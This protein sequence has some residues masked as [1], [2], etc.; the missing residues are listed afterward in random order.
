MNK[1]RSLF[2]VLTCSLS[3]LA[4]LS[5]QAHHAEFMATKPFIQGLSM[6]VHG[7]DHL[8]SALA[9][10]LIISLNKGRMRG[11]LLMLFTLVAALGGLL[12]LSGIS[13]PELA[14]PL[15]VLA[16]GLALW[17]GLPSLYLGA[18]L[19]AIA[20]LVNGQALI[21]NAPI[22]LATA[23]FALGCIVSAGVLSGVGVLIG[24]ALQKKQ[25]LIRFAGVAL[26]TG[27]AIVTL[28]PSVNSAILR[29]VE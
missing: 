20:G 7:V 28:F 23:V 10:G 14:V 12:N 13:L 5:V 27:A 1:S 9:V 26:I 25:N 3:L 2:P 21:E 16:S 4:P 11:G 29:V 18:F 15:T 19:I 22:N 6:P 24:S 17:N 8:L